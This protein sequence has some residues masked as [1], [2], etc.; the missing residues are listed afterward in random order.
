[1]SMLPLNREYISIATY[2]RLFL[3]D[4]L[5]QNIDKCIYLDCDMIVEDDIEKLWKYDITNYYAGVVE[6]ESSIPNNSRLNLPL[7]NT[8]FNAGLLL[9]NLKKL[10][11]INFK[12]KAFE[13]FYKNKDIIEFQDQD[14]LNGLF[15]NHCLLLPL[16]WNV[17]S[18]VYV[19]FKTHHK[20]TKKEELE[21]A[22]E[23][24]ILHFTGL[25]KPWLT[26]SMHPLNSEYKKYLTYTKFNEDIKQYKIKDFL[27][28][29]FCIKRDWKDT[30]IYILRIRVFKN[31]SI[32]KIFSICNTEQKKHK[33]ITILG[34][35]IKLKRWEKE[36]A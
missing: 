34:I 5:P 36:N 8:Y 21:A 22:Q 12:E 30:K 11:S 17:N 24:A 1:M 31:I 9:L 7:N 18:S 3:L 26:S 29:F 28:N 27:S 35:R 4:V 14:I 15:A 13:Y 10:R 20:Y 16:R 19:K 2:Y 32:K 6:D 33:V 23:P 25:Y